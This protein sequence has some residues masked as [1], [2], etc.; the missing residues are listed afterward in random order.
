M[1]FSVT[2]IEGRTAARHAFRVGRGAMLSLGKN[3]GRGRAT[4][5]IRMGI[6]RGQG[7]AAR[8][9]G[10]WARAHPPCPS[11]GRG[12]VRMMAAP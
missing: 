10:W 12:A 4:P 11:S 7:L 2:K 5:I 6:Q 3:G 1:Q 8:A 9:R